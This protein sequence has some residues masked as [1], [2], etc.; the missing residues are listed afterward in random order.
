MMCDGPV[1]S[2]RKVAANR[3]D[4]RG[5]RQPVEKSHPLQQM[6]TC[7]EATTQ[8][9]MQTIALIQTKAVPINANG[10]GAMQRCI[11]FT[12]ALGSVAALRRTD[13]PDVLASRV[14]SG[15][16]GVHTRDDDDPS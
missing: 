4:Y 5:H 10:N 3:L 15:A 16:G 11:N 2:V 13:L 12:V 8:K 14:T 1:C 9:S 6:R 7:A